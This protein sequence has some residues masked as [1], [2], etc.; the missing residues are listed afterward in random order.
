MGKK[1]QPTY[2]IVVTPKDNP[3]QGQYLDLLGTYNPIKQDVQIDTEKAV[4]WLNKGAQP[5]ERLARLLSKAGVSHKSIVIKTYTPKPKEE[6]KEE[7]PAEAPVAE[8]VAD[9]AD[10]TEEK[11]EDSTPDETPSEAVAEPAETEPATE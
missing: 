5:S 4:E 3:V 9:P 2:R 1:H 6:V 11:A 10:S 8:E 7:A